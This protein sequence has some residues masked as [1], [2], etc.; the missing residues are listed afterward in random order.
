VNLLLTGAVL[1]ALVTA[2]SALFLGGAGAGAAAGGF[3]LV[4]LAIQV[5]AHRLASGPVVPRAPFPA[6]WLWG[7]ALRFGGVVLLAVAVLLNR[8]L[9]PPL[10]AALG[11]LGVLIPLFVLELRRTR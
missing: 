1:V 3:G 6:G 8:R 7:T 2:L 5:I 11:Y 10:P 9:F 4:A